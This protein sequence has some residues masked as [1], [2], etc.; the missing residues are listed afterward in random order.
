MISENVLLLR[1]E[2]CSTVKGK[3]EIGTVELPDPG[4][5]EGVAAERESAGCVSFG[6][7]FDV[8][9]VQQSK[10]T[11]SGHQKGCVGKSREDKPGVAEEGGDECFGDASSEGSTVVR[12]RAQD[13]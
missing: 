5:A 1:R 4:C 11:D 10:E 9:G 3:R 12:W 6:E 2:R 13:K 8:Y 7:E